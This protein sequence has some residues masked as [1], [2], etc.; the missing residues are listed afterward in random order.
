MLP[1]QSVICECLASDELKLFGFRP[2]LTR[3]PMAI[4]WLAFFKFKFG[5]IKNTAIF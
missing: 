3:V 5:G 2:K 1:P 4:G